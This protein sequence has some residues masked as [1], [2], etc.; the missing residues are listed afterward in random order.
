MN[1]IQILILIVLII[2]FIR[3]L[4]DICHWF[5]DLF[6]KYKK[7]EYDPFS[8]ELTPYIIPDE[9]KKDLI[10]STN[11]V[12]GRYRVNFKESETIGGVTNN[13]PLPATIKP[14]N[15][16]LSVVWDNGWSCVIDAK[17]LNIFKL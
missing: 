12:K 11:D 2:I 7:E 16:R 13:D 10:P 3:Y 14:H 5:Q 9:L 8:Y 17:A 6:N 4:D 15:G 1:H